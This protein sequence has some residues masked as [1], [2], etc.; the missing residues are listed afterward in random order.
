MEQAPSLLTPCSPVLPLGFPL[1]PHRHLKSQEPAASSTLLG[2]QSRLSTV[3]RMGFLMCLHTHLQGEECRYPQS[4]QAR[5]KALRPLS[6]SGWGLHELPLATSLCQQPGHG[7]S[8]AS[9]AVGSCSTSLTSPSGSSSAS[10]SISSLT[11]LSHLYL[12]SIIHPPPFHPLPHLHLSIH[13][14]F[15]LP[16]LFPSIH[17]HPLQTGGPKAAHQSF[18]CSK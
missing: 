2:C 11:P 10:S 17:P 1:F 18:S 16:T 4:P 15:H 5:C 8:A 7:D 9:P 3:E 6:G 12:Q 14:T 13:P